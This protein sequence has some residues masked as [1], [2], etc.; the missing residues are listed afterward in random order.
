MYEAIQKPDMDLASSISNI[1]KWSNQ[2]IRNIL[3]ES[4]AILQPKYQ[5][6]YT[7][8]NQSSPSAGSLRWTVAQAL[9]K[10]LPYHM[11]LLSEQ[12]G[13][14]HIEFDE[15]YIEK[16]QL[17]KVETVA[18]IPCRLINGDR[19]KQLKGE[20]IN[21]FLN[22]ELDIDFSEIVPINREPI[23]KILMHKNLNQ[24]QFD[25]LSSFT[26]NERHTI[27]ILGGLL[28]F[29]ILKLILTKR[30]RVNYGVDENGRRQM[31]VPFKAKDFAA[32]MTEFGH[33]DV[34]IGFTLLSYYYSGE[35][36]KENF[37]QIY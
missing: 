24:V 31:A 2:K 18:F 27:L 25:V 15:S 36:K 26:L 23:R 19:F 10:R 3:D 29:E 13:K 21:D 33:P 20:L 8:G 16:K 30:W 6:V 12:Y 9:F 5:L 28:R 32:E 17:Q 22:G 1:L 11:R 14:D 4:D 37:F 7:V 35:N 34:A